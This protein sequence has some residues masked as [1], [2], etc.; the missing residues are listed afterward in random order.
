MFEYS[1]KGLPHALIHVT[2]LVER[3]GHH[4]AYDTCVAESVHKMYI[5]AA[6]KYSRTY[7][8][9]NESELHMLRFVQRQELWS[10]VLELNDQKL[11]EEYCTSQ[12]S[13]KDE[14]EAL[15]DD[16]M[17]FRDRNKLMNR[18]SYDDS[19]YTIGGDHGRLQTPRVWGATLL[20]ARILV[21]RDE[22]LTLLREKLG[23]RVTLQNNLRLATELQWEF[24]GSYRIYVQQ[25]K[26]YRKFVGIWKSAPGR[27]D[28]V[29]PR[30][31][32]RECYLCQVREYIH[33]SI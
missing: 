12:S 4:L 8:N 28:F 3:G 13:S 24:Y 27:K 20:S 19:W 26:S 25:S 1:Q 22:L 11:K 29:R 33:A 2:E 30:T 5:K 31:S 7:A 9:Q 10:S 18:L 14:D 16:S 17:I 21:S 6:A 23:M 32:H 15:E